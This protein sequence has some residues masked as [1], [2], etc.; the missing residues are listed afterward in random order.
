[1]K[2]L[3]FSEFPKVNIGTYI[4]NLPEETTINPNSNYIKIIIEKH[5][6][7]SISKEL[8]ISIRT[9]N[10]YLSQ[11]RYP[12]SFLKKL[13][14]KY[15][16]LDLYYQ[17]QRNDT[18]YFSRWKKLTLP[19]YLTPKLVYLIGYLQGD[20]SIEKNQ[21][22]INFTDEYLEQIQEINE[23]LFSIFGIRGKIYERST[24]NSKKPVYTLEAGSKTLNYFLSSV[25][26]IN[27]GIKK[28]LRIPTK[29]KT[30]KHL[31]KWYL[32]GLYDADGTLPKNP[33]TCKQLF[34]DITLKDK[35][36]IVEIQKALS[37]FNIY[38]LKPFCRIAKSP[39]SDYISRT[40]ELRIRKKGQ[41]IRFL[42]QIGFIHPN[43]YL[44]QTKFLRLMRL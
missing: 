33:Y 12:I 41:Q 3:I 13:K 43:K 30:S 20:G 28:D 17:I 29:I 16:I 24:S 23:I 39:N 4:E 25:F 19:T 40:W 35:E 18:L 15:N 44:R 8:N 6:N 9:I 2:K 22:R 21:K 32:S 1:M 42:K 27:R 36:F 11:N 7:K 10:K 38:T 31:L 5:T 37:L 34:I 26:K 14:F